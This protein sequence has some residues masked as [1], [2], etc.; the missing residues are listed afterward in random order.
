MNKNKVI[1][2]LKE[3]RVKHWIKNLI[4]FMPPFFG[5]VFFAGSHILPLILMFIA[6]CLAASAVYIINDLVDLELDRVHLDKKNRPLAA[7]LVSKKEAAI[8]S[9]ILLLAS[10]SLLLIIGQPP[11]FIVVT[12]YLLANLIYSFKIKNIALW[13]L[14][15]VAGM[16]LL[17][18][19]AGS[20][21][22]GIAVSGWLFVTVFFGS[23]LI[24]LGKRYSEI[25][26]NK[27]RPVLNFYTPQILN[28]FLLLTS[29]ITATAF[30][31]YSINLGIKYLP[32][33]VVFSFAIFRY[34]FLLETT[35]K[36]EKPELLLLE[37][38]QILLSILFLIGYN[39][40]LI[41]FMH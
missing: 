33:I 18:L 4:I 39:G 38:I 11:A 5:G 7:G 25:R 14:F 10:I 8:T 21:V 35:Q 31:I 12:G 13:D 40:F 30:I 34:F 3:L 41:Y 2:I 6:F 19:Y 23:L 22:S 36:G 16:Y 27:V 28:S 26:S 20:V 24:I 37:D 17:R 9:A 15:F 32:A 29:A 1:A